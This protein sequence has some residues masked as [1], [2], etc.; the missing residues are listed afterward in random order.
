M[1]KKELNICSKKIITIPNGINPVN[2]VKD[3]GN[4]LDIYKKNK[5]IL[6]VSNLIKTK[7]ID[8]NLKVIEKLKEK[9]PNLIYL[10][11]GYGSE[12]ENLKK[13]AKDLK[14][15]QLYRVSR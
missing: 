4:P 12:R 6:S 2:S 14:I 5:I 15:F 10:I 8:F 9:Y 11:V 1:G 13:L 3:K 7:G